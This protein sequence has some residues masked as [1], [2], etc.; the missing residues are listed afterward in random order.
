MTEKEIQSRIQVALCEK[1]CKVFRSNT[2]NFFTADGRRIQTYFKGFSDLHGH[3]P[4][5]K[6]F[7]I[8]VKDATGRPS[9]EQINFLY[10]MRKSGAIAG[11]CRSVESSIKLVFGEE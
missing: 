3:R 6:A 2:G 4:D 10:E 1:G 9:K 7:Y 5:G 11:I 8:E